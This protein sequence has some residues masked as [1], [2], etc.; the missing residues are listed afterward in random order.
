MNHK[1]FFLLK[2]LADLFFA[3][4]FLVLL[5]PVFL[6]V[7]MAVLIFDGWPIFFLQERVGKNWR[8]F[9]MYK[10]RTMP[11]NAPKFAIGLNFKNSR[12][13]IG[14][15]L[16]RVNIDEL[17]QLLNI[18]IG[19]MS[20]VGPRPEIKVFADLF[21]SRE[22]KIFCYKPGLTSPASLTYINED[23]LLKKYKD[24]RQAYIEKIVPD[25]IG[26]DLRY[27]KKETLDGDLKIVL[28]TAK[29]ILMAIFSA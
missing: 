3:F 19:N 13:K 27:F 2:R 1:L 24:K 12:T 16:R 20:F 6:I 5:L 29:K 22:K 14:A 8:I 17:P 23:E 4:L 9:R 26:I 10:F 11:T 7:G 28:T 18:F 21:R 15:F 25:K